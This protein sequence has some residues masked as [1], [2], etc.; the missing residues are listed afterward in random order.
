[1]HNE[2]DLSPAGS[3]TPT[4]S[5]RRGSLA[6]YLAGLPS[7][8]F[9]EKGRANICRRLSVSADELAAAVATVQGPRPSQPTP[10]LLRIIGAAVAPATERRAERG[11]GQC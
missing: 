4:K 2:T 7:L 1:M 6:T 3:T 11:A 9:S 8:D 5:G 10:E